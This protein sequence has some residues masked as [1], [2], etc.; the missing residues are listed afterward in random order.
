MPQQSLTYEPEGAE[1]LVGNDGGPLQRSLFAPIYK[2]ELNELERQVAVYMDA[3]QSLAWW[4]RSARAKDSADAVP[5]I[6]RPHQR[7]NRPGRPVPE[8]PDSQQ[9]GHARPCQ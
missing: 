4:H 8:R 5:R 7:Q 1:Q 9:G 6:G 3:E 2:N